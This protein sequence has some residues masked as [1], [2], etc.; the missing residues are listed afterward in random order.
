MIRGLWVMC[1]NKEDKGPLAIDSALKELSKFPK[2]D[3]RC[4]HLP[5]N[6]N[7]FLLRFICLKFKAVDDKTKILSIYR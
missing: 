6:V 1:T 7:R 5:L 2:S 3:F 4:S